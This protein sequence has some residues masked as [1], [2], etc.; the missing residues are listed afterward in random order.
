[1]VLD[2]L[3]GN[4]T[5]SVLVKA[6]E[7]L[8]HVGLLI[9][10]AFVV[11]AADVLR[12]L[13]EHFEC[14]SLNFVLKIFVVGQLFSGC[15]HLACAGRFS[16]DPIMLQQTEC[17]QSLLGVPAHQLFN[18]VDGRFRQMRRDGRIAK[19]RRTTAVDGGPDFVV[20]CLAVQIV[21]MHASEHDV[22][23]DPQRPHVHGRI[24]LCQ[25][26]ALLVIQNFGWTVRDRLA[27]QRDGLLFFFLCKSFAPLLPLFDAQVAAA[28]S[29]AHPA[30]TI[31]VAVITVII[32]VIIVVV[33]IR[34]RDL[35]TAKI[36]QLDRRTGWILG[37]HH[38]ILGLHVGMN[39]VQSVQKV[40]RRCHLADQMGGIRLGIRA[41]IHQ[42]IEQFPAT[43][44][45]QHQ[46]VMAALVEVI[47]QRANA[48]MPAGLSQMQQRVHFS[49]N[50]LF[51]GEFFGNLFEGHQLP[52]FLVPG[53]VDDAERAF[54][55]AFGPVDVV[56]ALQSLFG[57]AGI[58]P[59]YCLAPHG[60]EF[61][62]LLLSRKGVC[63]ARGGVGCMMIGRCRCRRC[64]Q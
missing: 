11:V 6:L 48:R 54:S 37:T 12:V 20:G 32:V 7:D 58:Q 16:P 15:H 45:I 23:D 35:R 62:R 42:M 29:L 57:G 63:F 24:E 34:F 21:R 39:D 31:R 17:V 19:W 55:D 50:L 46:V 28:A 38:Q 59:S 43:D 1:M 49:H 8:F 18:Q 25:L 22:Q 14:R 4:M 2:I 13:D 60:E 27:C 40:Q 3:L 9:P 44:E 47:A 41:L 51:F 64:D 30:V 53:L 26:A 56:L 10:A 52:G 61:R 36:D 5:L 33:V